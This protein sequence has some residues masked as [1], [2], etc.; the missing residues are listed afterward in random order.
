MSAADDVGDGVRAYGQEALLVDVAGAAEAARLATAL[1]A[2]ATARDR[3]LVDVVPAART[4]LVR[5]P[6]GTDLAE[7]AGW[8]RSVRA[9]RSDE[10]VAEGRDVVVDVVYDGADL[11]DVAAATGLDVAEVVARHG[12]ATYRAAFAGFAPGF[13][14]LTGLDPALHLPRRA[15]PRKRVPAGSVAVA[16]EFSA[17][18]PR[19]GPGGWHLLGRTDAVMF[20]AGADRPA[21]VQPGD[22]VRFHPVPAPRGRTR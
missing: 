9:R 3:P 8:A 22:R 13:V 2:D 6:P 5:V 17:V 20:D 4:V 14:Y 7:V 21:L 18:Y 16:A 12:A 15:T 10:P 11:D 19:S 1:R